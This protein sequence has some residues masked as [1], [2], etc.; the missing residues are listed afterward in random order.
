ML[1]IFK[2][3]GR[4]R[5]KELFLFFFSNGRPPFVRGRKHN[6]LIYLLAFFL[7]LSLFLTFLLSLSVFLY[8]VRRDRRFVSHAAIAG[9]FET[10]GRRLFLPLFLFFS[11][12]HPPVDRI[13]KIIRTRIPIVSI[14]RNGIIVELN[15]GVGPV[16]SNMEFPTKKENKER[17]KAT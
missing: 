1:K 14:V 11:S 17:S 12:L 16:R 9:G 7:A 6:F 4:L 13:K 8:R 15:F 10:F 5:K 2:L 3:D